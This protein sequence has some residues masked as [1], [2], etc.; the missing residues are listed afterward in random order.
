MARILGVGIATVDIVNI[1]DHYPTED[2]ELRAKSQH[3]VRGGNVTNTLCVLSQLGHQCEWLGTLAEEPDSKII[4]DD[5]D[6]YKINYDKV[7]TYSTGKVPTSYITLSH[8]TGS[9][10]IVHYRDLPELQF[11]DIETFDYTEYDW[12]HF[13]GRNVEQLLKLV[14][15]IKLLHPGI[16]LSLEVEKE[17]EGIDSLFAYMEVLLFSKH[18]SLA[19]GYTQAVD[20]L[21]SLDLNTTAICAWGDQGSYA[22]NTHKEIIFSAAEK[23]EKVV[24]SIGAGDTFNAGII[25]SLINRRPLETCLKFANQLAGKKIQQQGFSGISD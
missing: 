10:T 1:V 18:Y 13:E 15:H 22:I 20:L 3:K 7:I 23:V 8:Q 19:K 5:L 14:A 25:D 17:R 21:N 2:E 12:I 4:K 16:P 24:D 11:N 9:R 6:H